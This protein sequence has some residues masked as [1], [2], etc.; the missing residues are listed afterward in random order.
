MNI[1]KVGVVGC[2]TM[3]SGIVTQCAL[4]NYD[5]VFVEVNDNLVTKGLNNIKT[6]LQKG[7]ER[8]KF[9]KDEVDRTISRIHGTTNFSELKD[10]DIA[11]EAVIENLDEK[12]KVFS[13]LDKIC[14]PEAILASNT[15]SLSIT[16]LASVTQRPEKVVGIHFMNPVPIMKLVELV[17]G[18]RTSEQTYRIAKEFSESLGKVT[19]TANDNPAF[20]VNY[21]L[22]PYLLDAVRALEQGIAT[23]ED[24]DTGMKLGCGHPMGPI[25]LLDFVGLDTTLYI[26][27]A[28]YEEYKEPRWIAPPLLRKM[29]T[30]G[31]VGKKVG[32]GFYDYQQNR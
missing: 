1:K 3:G 4:K 9:T 30:A 28:M 22:I 26:A 23:K 17:K 13:T 25:E 5:V 14:K 20:I 11:I 16:K 8:G 18:L 24:I 10:V 27:D 29:V 12:L 2:G 32:R 19:I 6:F 21:L 7:I 31:F 15:S